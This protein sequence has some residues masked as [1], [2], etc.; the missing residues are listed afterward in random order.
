MMIGGAVMDAD[1]QEWSGM[2]W[3]EHKKAPGVCIDG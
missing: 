3:S 2:S 1:S